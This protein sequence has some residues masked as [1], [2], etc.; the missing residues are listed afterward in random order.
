MSDSMTVRLLKPVKKKNQSDQVVEILK[1]YIASDEIQIGDKLPPELTLAQML[2]VSRSTI[3]EAIRTLSV[4]GYIRIVNG[5]GSFLL[6]KEIDMPKEQIRHWFK[7][8]NMELSEF[9][10]VRKMIEPEAIVLAIR[11]GTNEEFEKLIR[12]QEEFESEL[13]SSGPNPHLG[14]LDASFHQMIIDMAHNAVLTQMNRVLGESFTDY[15][16][17]SFQMVNH[18]EN[19]VDPHRRILNAMES[20]DEEEALLQL[21]NHLDMVYEDMSFEKDST[22]PDN[23]EKEV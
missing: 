14:E 8:H 23:Q 11:R 7:H 13:K 10:E 2:D 5:K 20:K 6:R 4:M 12:I 19:A 15:R 18:A 16:S 17:R 3:R 21:R 22:E 9:I 1:Q